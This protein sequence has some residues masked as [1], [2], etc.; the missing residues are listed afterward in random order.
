[1]K[2]VRHPMRNAFTTRMSVVDVNLH[3]RREAQHSVGARQST[4]EHLFVR[5]A[6]REEVSDTVPDWL[7]YP[8][9]SLFP[10]SNQF[11]SQYQGG[12]C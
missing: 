12:R 3:F 7:R 8:E 1:M 4:C 9:L 11:T 10:A 2:R 5:V 6:E